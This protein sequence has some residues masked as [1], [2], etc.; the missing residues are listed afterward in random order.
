MQIKTTVTISDERLKDLLCGAFEGG[1]NYWINHVEIPFK[2]EDRKGEYFHEMPV[3]GQHL[4]VHTEE[5][6]PEDKR[7][8]TLDRAALERGMQ[9]FA[10]KYP[11]SFY[12]FMQENEDAGTSD[13]FL[14]C[15]IFGDA[16]YG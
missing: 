1:S 9:I 15:C 2:K 14:Q 10:D 7:V 3:Y 6:A 8:V 12:E 5:D 4:I 13:E 11:K 16:I